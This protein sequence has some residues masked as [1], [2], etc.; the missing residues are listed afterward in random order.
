MTTVLVFV[1]KRFF[2]ILNG[3]DTLYLEPYQEIIG[4]LQ[5]IHTNQ[6][7]LVAVFQIRHEIEIYIDQK[8]LE[9]YIGKKIRIFNNNGQYIIREEKA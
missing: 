5:E 9:P 1:S 8:E 2:Q 6:L 4:V 3:E 7:V